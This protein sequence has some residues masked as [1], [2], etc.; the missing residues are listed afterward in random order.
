M[1]LAP[2]G[3][4]QLEL[5][6][7]SAMHLTRVPSQM[8]VG[9][10]LCRPLGPEWYG[11]ICALPRPQPLPPKE[12]FLEL[13]ASVWPVAPFRSVLF[14]LPGLK[15]DTSGK[16]WDRYLCRASDPK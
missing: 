4:I 9:R 1:S 11:P 13:A 16:L 15:F 5:A 3:I 12:A 10:V 2:F 14:H 6:P 7:A 8:S